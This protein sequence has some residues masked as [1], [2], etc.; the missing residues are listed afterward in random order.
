MFALL[1]QAPQAADH[2][3]W[4]DAFAIVG[5]EINDSKRRHPGRKSQLEPAQELSDGQELLMCL[6]L[7]AKNINLHFMSVRTLH[8][9][10]PNSSR[11]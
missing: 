6:D 8:Y 5:G 4:P 3:T 2:L 7:T 10:S 11:K 1:Q 9:S